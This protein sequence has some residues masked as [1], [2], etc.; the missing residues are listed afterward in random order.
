[1]QYLMATTICAAIFKMTALA[2]DNDTTEVLEDIANHARRI[3]AHATEMTLGVKS[4]NFDRE[5]V[6]WR[7][8]NTEESVNRSKERV[9]AVDASSPFWGGDEKKHLDLVKTKVELP[10]IFTDQKEQM[11][12]E[13]DLSKKESR[14]RVCAESLAKRAALLEQSSGK[15]AQAEEHPTRGRAF[16]EQLWQ[17]SAPFVDAHAAHP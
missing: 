15:L 2:S 14:R 5:K 16:I 13:N 8:G 1:M 11:L 3:K 7:T 6:E 10:N 12:A 9:N 4:K 17:E